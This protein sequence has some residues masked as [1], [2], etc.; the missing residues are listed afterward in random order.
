[1]TIREQAKAIREAMDKAGMLLEASQAASLVRLYKPWKAFEVDQNNGNIEK[2]VHYKVGER[3]RFNDFV[4]ECRQEHDSQEL[5]N[6]EL[7][8]ALWTKLNVDHTG[9]MED[10]IPYSS[11]MIIEKD[12][13]YSEDGI[14]YLCTRNSEYPLYHNLKDLIGQYV[15]VV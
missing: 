7:A 2:A 4:Y 6:P 1:M 15:E 5:Y 8:P 14:I 9:G 12:K 3:C 13:Y 11:G 10:P